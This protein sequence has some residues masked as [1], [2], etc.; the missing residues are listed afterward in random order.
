[1]QTDLDEY[2]KHYNFERPLQ[3]RGMEVG[4]PYQVF[5]IGVVETKLE[6][7]NQ[8]PEAA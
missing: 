6:E 5:K 8:V 2:L 3:G 7:E 1:M 4:I